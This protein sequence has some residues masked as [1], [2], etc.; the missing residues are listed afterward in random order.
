MPPVLRGEDSIGVPEDQGSLFQKVLPI[1]T[2]DP[3]DG[4]PAIRTLEPADTPVVEEPGTPPLD[5]QASTT[6]T[7][8][9]FQNI[10]QFLVRRPADAVPGSPASL[11]ELPLIV[12]QQ[13]PIINDGADAAVGSFQPAQIVPPVVPTQP[14]IRPVDNPPAA[15]QP[16]AASASAT[17]GGP[18]INRAF[19]QWAR[20][21]QEKLL[22]PAGQNSIRQAEQGSANPGLLPVRR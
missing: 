20:A 14:I 15:N 9:I 12:E 16:L 11:G 5:P 18:R 4:L 8:S 13:P 1:Q 7:S 2:D 3:T 19:M 10:N 22:R 17:N 21:N 6:G